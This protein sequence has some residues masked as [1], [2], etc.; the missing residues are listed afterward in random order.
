MTANREVRGGIPAEEWRLSP[1][2]DQYEVSSLGRVR[3]AVPSCK[4]HPAGMILKPRPLP[5]GYLRA[6]GDHYI[7]RL[8]CEAFNGSAPT[9][10]HEVAHRNGVRS[11]NRASNLYWATHTENEADKL[12]HGTRLMGTS[13][14]NS[15]LS[16]AEIPLI[17]ALSG[18]MPQHAIARR[19]GVSQMIVSKI[20]RREAWR[21]VA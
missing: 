4:G 15:K 2:C 17:R 14:G 11:D 19:F 9:P 7:H 8:V 18:K 13:V 12:S 16:E 5:N 20:V 3:R 6:A 21:H 10:K 1:S